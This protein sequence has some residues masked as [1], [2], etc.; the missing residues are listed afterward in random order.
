[1]ELKDVYQRI[2]DQIVAEPE[3]DVCPCRVLIKPRGSSSANSGAPS[4]CAKWMR[5]TR[6][7]KS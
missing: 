7:N 6:K 5:A 3:N 1:M 2:T 4:G